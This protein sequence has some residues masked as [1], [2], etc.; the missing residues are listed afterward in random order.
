LTSSHSKLNALVSYRSLRIEDETLI[1]QP[2]ENTLLGRI[3]Y[4]VTLFK[5]ALTANTFYEAGS[6]LELRKEFLYIEVNTG[7][8]V[9]TWIDYNGDGIKDLNEFEIAQYADQANYIRVFTPSNEYVRTYSNEFNQSIFWRPERIWA[10]EKGEKKFLARFSNQARFRISRKTSDQTLDSYNPFLRDIADTSLISFAST[11]R[12]TLFFNRTN[13]IFGADYTYSEVGSKILLA[14]G[15][16]GRLNNFHQINLRWNIKKKFTLTNTSELGTR[17]SSADYTTG[18]DYNISYYKVQP[19]FIFQPNTK[20]R[21]SLDLR[22]EDKENAQDFGGEIA[23]I[24]DIGVQ[25]K[26]NQA[27]QGSFQGGINA[28]NIT[29]DGAQNNALSFE[30]LESLRPGLNYTWTM[31]YQRSI[32]KNLQVSIQYNGRKSETND[33][34]HAG[35]VEVRAFF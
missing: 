34:I 6:G 21:V 29:Y 8:G 23:E 26:F 3:D 12:N 33:A 19:S 18:R 14:N 31:S 32:S 11:V 20:F 7:Q 35:G 30:M 22:W 15:F 1:N 28:V 10:N 16:D 13:A 5:S 2:P 4:S 24:R 25:F 27:E 17:S 9:Y